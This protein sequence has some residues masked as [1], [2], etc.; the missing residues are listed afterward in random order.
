MRQQG[1]R[2][3]RRNAPLAWAGGRVR[4]REGRG[5]QRARS[6][7]ACAKKAP[8]LPVWHRHGT[9]SGARRREQGIA[10][11]ALAAGYIAHRSSFLA[12]CAG[13]SSGVC[14]VRSH[15]QKVRNLDLEFHWKAE[16]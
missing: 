6:L 13:F 11:L 5:M 14:E 3:A 1:E 12:L 15:K 4:T 9:S 16:D 2:A 7:L 10:L 8:Y